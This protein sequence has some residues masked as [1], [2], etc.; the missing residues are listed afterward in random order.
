MPTNPIVA[1]K[2]VAKAIQ[3]GTLSLQKS[4]KI[5]QV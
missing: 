1:Y 4:S 5:G 3:N 2:L